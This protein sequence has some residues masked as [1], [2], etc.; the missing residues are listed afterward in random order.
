MPKMTCGIAVYFNYESVAD[1]AKCKQYVLL[2]KSFGYDEVFS[3][4]HLPEI[5]CNTYLSETAEFV[6]F[7][8]QSGMQF[9]MDISGHK[10]NQLL[11]DDTAKAKLSELPIDWLRMDYG[12]TDSILKAAAQV[13]KLTGIMCNASVLTKPEVSDII[14]R[15]DALGLKLRAHHNFYPRPET[16]LSFD[17]MLN[18]SALYSRYDIPVTACVSSLTNP[19]PPVCCGL[20]TVEAHRSLPPDIAAYSLRSTGLLSSVLIGD[21]FADE[22]ELT[23]VAAAC[24]DPIVLRVVPNPGITAKE[25]NIM[26]GTTHHSRPDR[27]CY[28]IRSESSREMASFGCSIQP[29]PSATR[30]EFD[31]TIDNDNYLRY[32]GELQILTSDLPPDNRVNIAGHIYLKDQ[33]KV[34]AILPGDD[35][36]LKCEENL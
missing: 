18:K 34:P 30:K 6:R 19:R 1:I 7:V 3:S 5:N 20:P 31:V 14:S 17:F 28:S 2:A 9:S 10:L 23:S 22:R 12:F 8:K 11:N 26:F 35:F 4:L 16:G 15:A 32:S 13:L 21:P 36:I 24:S 29:R 27:S 25:R 33:M